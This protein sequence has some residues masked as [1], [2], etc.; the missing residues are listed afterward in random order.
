LHTWGQNLMDHPHIHYL[1]PGGGLN[2]KK[3]RWISSKQKYL[4]PVK[5]LSKVF[6]GK[7]LSNLEALYQRGELK[8]NGQIESLKDPF[9]FKTLLCEAARKNWVVYSKEP[10]AGPKQVINYL[11]RYTHRIAI[12]NHRLI[13][14]EDNRVHFKYRDY[15]DDNKS[16]V[17]VLNVGE[18]MRRFLL[19]VL[20]KGYVRIRHFGIL[21]SRCKIKNLELI[22]KLLRVICVTAK[23]VPKTA[24]ELLKQLLGIDITIC[25]SCHAILQP[26]SS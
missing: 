25:P 9:R 19:H 14:M 5:V 7:F 20:P 3:S 24:A 16:K 10:F 6:E 26:N 22:R 11:G 18:F 12:S 15:S 4:L 1:V 8:L 17:M 23:A 21:A 13:K 2:D